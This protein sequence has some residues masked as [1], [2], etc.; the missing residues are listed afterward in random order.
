MIL[1]RQFI[2][3]QG[4]E[5]VFISKAVRIVLEND[6]TKR[7]GRRCVL[8]ESVSSSYFAEINLLSLD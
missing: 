3:V 8:E 6:G 1:Q 2:E 5:S 4:C 7:S